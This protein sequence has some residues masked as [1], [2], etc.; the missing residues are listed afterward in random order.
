M[1]NEPVLDFDDTIFCLDCTV[2]NVHLST[3]RYS[4]R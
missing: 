4:R 2:Y 3:S 1:I